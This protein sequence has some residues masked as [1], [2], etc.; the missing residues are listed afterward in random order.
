MRDYKRID[1][2][3]NELML[4]IYPQPPD[5]GHTA[6]AM[7]VIDGW[8]A[9]IADQCG[10]V[11]DVGCG[12]GFL[13][14]AF[15]NLGFGYV[16]VSLGADVTEAE[17]KTRNVWEQDFHFLSFADENFDLVFSRHALEHSPMPLFALMEWHRVSRAWLCL[18]L[19]NPRFWTDYGKNHYS[20]L[21]LN[22]TKFLL[23]RAGW[24]II[25]QDHTRYEFRF[26][27]QKVERQVPFHLEEE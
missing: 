14:E 22:Q 26:L 3:Y 27:C 7:E 8:I 20:V 25:S 16:G 6:W 12:E 13:Q 11:L 1:E 15:E 9:S 17:K 2:Y 4:D 21:R 19:P 10:N 5:E 24:E 18:I 23:D